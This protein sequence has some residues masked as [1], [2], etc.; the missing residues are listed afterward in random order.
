MVLIIITETNNERKKSMKYKYLGKDNYGKPK[1]D[2]IDKIKLMNEDELEKETKNKIWL[3]AWAANNLKSDYHWHVDA[4]Y[5][6]LK[7]RYDN[8]EKYAEYFKYVYDN[9]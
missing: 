3:S 8:D 6:E 2:Y 1:S 7:N 9:R 4:C 5:D